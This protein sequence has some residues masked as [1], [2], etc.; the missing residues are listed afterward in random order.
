M[1]LALAPLLLAA[2]LGPGAAAQAVDQPPPAV[3]PG[4]M[5]APGNMGGG[6]LAGRMMD[7]GAMH[8]MGLS[9]EHLASAKADLNLTSKQLPSWIA[10][11]DTVKA[12]RQLMG[13]GMMQ[14][15]GSGA[16]AQPG[17]GMMMA[18]GSLPERLE[19]HE[20]M[21]SAHLEALR[22][23]R[24][25]AAQLYGHLTPDQRSK[26]DRLLCGQIAASGA[27]AATDAPAEP[28]H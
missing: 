2:A 17:A 25:A 8:C 6:M 1:R 10:F 14:G 21:M 12:N 26:A 22:R 3:Q 4:G 23:T 24:V 27:S 5:A 16:G 19:R 11:V 18:P 7:M 20:K 28:V 9:D 13:P 15:P